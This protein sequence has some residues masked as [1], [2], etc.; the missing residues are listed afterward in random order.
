MGSPTATI[1]GGVTTTT[2]AVTAVAAGSAVIHASAANLTDATANV[3][4]T[5]GTDIIVPASLSVP[6]GGSVILPI[7]LANP[8]PTLMFF[9]LTSNDP[10]KATLSTPTIT[11]PAGQTVSS[12]VVRVIGVATGATTIKVHATNGTLADATTAVTVAYT[13][14]ITPAT[15]T[16]LGNGNL[17]T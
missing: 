6:P 13:L 10:T 5:A 11:I 1:Q 4:V 12:N 2:I 8:A 3:T 9:D 17:A 16:I 15:L 7:T 14:T